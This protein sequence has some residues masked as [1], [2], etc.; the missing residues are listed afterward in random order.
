MI[1]TFT[2]TSSEHYDRHQYQ[3]ELN[4]GDK[5]LFDTYDQVKAFWFQNL[6]GQSG[7]AI[8]ILDKKIKKKSGRGF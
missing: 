4:T 8:T 5:I 7:C 2:H 3:L 1:D 6:M